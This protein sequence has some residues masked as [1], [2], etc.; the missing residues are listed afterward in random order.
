MRLGAPLPQKYADPA[1]WVAAIQT[2]GYRAAYC[3][4]DHTATRETIAAFAAAAQ[5]ANI[6]IAEVGAWSN[7]LSPDDA[8]RKRAIE[9]CQ[10]QL[11]L[12]D[13]I[14][15]RCC[16]NITGSR[17]PRWDGPHP[18][19]L[20]Q[21]TFDLI[22]E[23]IRGI[24]DAVKPRRAFWTIETMPWMYPDSLPVYLQLLDAIDRSHCAAHFDPV[25]WINSPQRYFANATLIRESVRA[26]GPRIKS[27]HVK[28]ITLG[29]SLMVHLDEV[30][31]GLGALDHATLLRELAPLDADL[32]VMLEHLPNQAEY[33]LAAAHIRKVADEVGAAL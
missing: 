5:S 26:L 28:D 30:R 19:N 1:A 15:A 4:V 18:D 27:V 14:G 9:L 6:V 31:P 8:E 22:V 10:K 11:A 24:I 16:V 33:A 2:L 13:E 25:N 12:A 21:A 20:T 29:D 32:P 17:G 23:T 3:P 7:P